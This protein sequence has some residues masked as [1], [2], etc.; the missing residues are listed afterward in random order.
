MAS[1]ELLQSAVDRIKRPN[2]YVSDILDPNRAPRHVYHNDQAPLAVVNRK[3][4]PR[5]VL[6]TLASFSCS[7]AFKDNRPELVWDSTAQE[8]VEERGY[9]ASVERGAGILRAGS[10]N[11][12]P[13]LINIKIPLEIEI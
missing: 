1:V 7:Y 5:R 11:Y 13:I 6:P 12:C 10:R 8:M 2:T 9:C 4:E 3:G